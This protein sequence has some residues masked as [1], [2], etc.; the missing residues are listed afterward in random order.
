MI[1]YILWGVWGR[2]NCKISLCMKNCSKTKPKIIQLKFIKNSKPSPPPEFE[3]FYGGKDHLSRKIRILEWR[4]W[5]KIGYHEMSNLSFVVY[6]KSERLLN[7]ENQLRQ[8]WLSLLL[9]LFS[10]LLVLVM[11]L[12]T[13]LNERTAKV[14]RS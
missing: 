6:L 5:L 8:T 11:T 14:N 12:L 1:W 2:G 7:K 13:M 4:K 10:F 3:C 9:L